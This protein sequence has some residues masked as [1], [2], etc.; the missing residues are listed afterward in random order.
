MMLANY[1]THTRLCDGVGEPE[2]YVKAAVKKGFEALGFSAHAPLPKPSEWTLQ[3]NEITGYISEINRLKR[4]YQDSITVYLGLEVDYIPN[5]MGPASEEIT[6]LDID[7]SIGSVHTFEDPVSGNYYGIDGPLEEYEQ[8]F[9]GI[10]RENMEELVRSYYGRMRE[11]IAGDRLDVVGHFDLVKLRNTGEYSYSETDSWYRDEVFATL[12][13][14]SAT[15]GIL[16]VN[17]GGMTRGKVE[18]FYPSDWIVKEAYEKNIPVTIS[19]DAHR[20]DDLDA[21]F[22]EAR[23]LLRSIGFGE[24]YILCNDGWTP[25]PL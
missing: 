6:Q 22:E 19:S 14:L 3:K 13:E 8:V 16:E 18:T 1:H 10:Y 5:R 9:K 17:T 12:E 11:L 7:Y 21:Y 25:T 15:G 20:P 2:E 4:A 24:I 23:Q